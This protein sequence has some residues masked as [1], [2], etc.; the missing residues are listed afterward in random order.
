MLVVVGIGVRPEVSLA[1]AAGL[2]LDRGV[3]V[4]ERL[5]TSAPGVFAAGDIARY[6]YAP[7]GELVRILPD[8]QLPQGLLHLVFTSRRG[9]LPGVRA[10]I[11]F[12]SS[13]LRPSS[14]AWRTNV[15]ASATGK[16][17]LRTLIWPSS[18]KKR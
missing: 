15:M 5:Q 18:D 4:D 7:T 12:L 3:V 16:F 8:W 2:R 11:D 14:P 9:L 17:C 1:E 6:P 10:T 13:V